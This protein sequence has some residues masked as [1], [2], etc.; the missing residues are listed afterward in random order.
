MKRI[1][2]HDSDS[3]KMEIR[4]HC[5]ICLVI[6]SGWMSLLHWVDL[7]VYLE[8]KLIENSINWHFKIPTE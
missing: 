8:R 6:Q 3:H 4:I 7:H 5:R 1:V 2:E